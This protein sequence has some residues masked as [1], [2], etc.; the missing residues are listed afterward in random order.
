MLACLVAGAASRGL[1]HGRA[2]S[3]GLVAFDPVDRDHFV[4]RGTWA[5]L[6]TDDGGASFHWTCAVAVDFDRTTEDPAVALT[7]SGRLAVG[8]FDG[9]RLSDASACDYADGPDATRGAFAIDVQTDPS[10]P[11]GLYV[12]RSPGDAPNTIL[13]SVDEGASFQALTV[14]HETVLLER[15]RIAPSDTSRIYAS[16]A[17][18]TTSTTSR[19]AFVFRS[20]DGGATWASTEIALLREGEGIDERNVHVLAVDPTDADRVF[21]RVTRRT[22]DDTPERLLLSED[23]GITFRSVL[24]IPEITGVAISPDGA[25]VW[26][27]SY[28]GGLERSD[29]GGRTFAMLDADLRVR[30]LAARSDGASG[31]ELFVCADP[32]LSPYA[33]AR[34]VDLGATLE[35]LW[36]LTDAVNDVRCSA[37]TAVG[38]VCPL[39]WPDVVYDL[40][41]PDGSDGGVAPE[42]ID[43]GAAALCDEAGVPIDAS[44]DGGHVAPTRAS[45]CGCRA[46]SRAPG[47]MSLT[48]LGLVL[49]GAWIRLRRARPGSLRSMDA[50]R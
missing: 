45:T 27:G 8:T 47:A 46:S 25:H 48:A 32:F 18:P 41:L 28:Y 15:V 4:L 13:H 19:Q 16:G 9:L 11:R 30:C 35:P 21:V 49:L 3:V 1:A 40:A 50:R 42:P 17:V 37:C 23:G 6:T 26:A 34:S 36:S 5:L 2:P 33:V 38:A 20:I 22:T 7:Q 43:G 31:T 29:D 39:Y 24:E 44:L 14:P 12:V 10:D